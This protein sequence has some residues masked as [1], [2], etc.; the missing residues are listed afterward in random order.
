[1]GCGLGVSVSKEEKARAKQVEQQLK[2]DKKV[3][4]NEVKLLLLGAGESGK[5]TIAK[6][7]KIIHL[8]GF[9]KEE[10]FQ[11]RDIIHSNIISSIK[12]LITAA[13][14]MGYSV[15]NALRTSVDMFMN[16]SSYPLEL[17]GDIGNEILAIWKDKAIQDAYARSSE[18]QLL[19]SA[20]YYIE[21]I[22]RICQKDYIPNQQDVL[23]SRCKTT[24]ITETE[25]EVENT[26]F[27]LVDVGGQRSERK[28]WIHCFEDVTAVIFCAALSEYDLKLYEDE[29]VNRM[30]ES[31]KL[32]EEICNSKWFNTVSIILFLNKSDLFKEKI[33]RVDLKVTF[34]DYTGGNNFDKATKFIEDKF[35]ALN[36]NSS[37][38]EIYTHV[39]CAT[40][41]ENITFVFNAVKNIILRKALEA[42]GF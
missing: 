41:T 32:F 26:K 38:K 3:F 11:F 14:D 1:M 40:D 13:H 20:P 15:S 9:T 42:S 8:E 24:G 16:S 30:H 36:A 34:P 7:M 10:C 4:E 17:N 33:R 18:Y 12:A 27:K 29:T 25:F 23:R 5:S 31:L 28:K 19:D 39:T 21:H 22:N 2:Q 35:S 37:Q 6:Q